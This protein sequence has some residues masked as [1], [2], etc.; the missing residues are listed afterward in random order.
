MDSMCDR[1][2]CIGKSV[3]GLTIQC[4][5]CH[6]HKYDTLKQEEY[7]RIFACINNDNKAQRVVYS[8]EEQR[9]VASLSRQMKD[10]EAGLRHTTPDWEERIATWEETVETTQPEWTPLKLSVED[11]STGGQRYLAQADDSFLAQG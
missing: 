7:C 9:T 10:L 11:I 2:D 4:A 6:D 5:Q 1:M 8:A 3:L